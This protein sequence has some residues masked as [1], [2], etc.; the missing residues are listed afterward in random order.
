M[1]KT[2]TAAG[3]V[4]A[5]DVY[6]AA[7]HNIIATDVNNLI[8]PAY[9][10]ITR[11][12]NQSIPH[13]TDT[14]VSLDTQIYDTDDMFA[15]TSSTITINTSGIWLVNAEA[16]FPETLNTRADILFFQGVTVVRRQIQYGTQERFDMTS[17][18]YI[19]SGTNCKFQVYQ[20]NSGATAKN[21]TFKA[22]FMWLGNPA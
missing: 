9:C 7:A 19:A 17:V 20:T 18:Q 10:Q 13:A 15:P 4:A 5:G 11:N 6:T 8:V 2:Y 22:A 3:T 21:L 16:Y 12:A 1:A 14:D